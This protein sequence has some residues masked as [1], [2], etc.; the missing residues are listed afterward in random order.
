MAALLV[1]GAAD[2]GWLASSY[3]AWRLGYARQLG[4]PWLVREG[5]PDR[6]LLSTFLVLVAIG[7]GLLLREGWR[8]GAL[9]LV[10]VGMPVLLASL[11]PLYGPVRAIAWIHAY[12]RVPRLAE[13]VGTGERIGLGG[14][15]VCFAS[16][17][18]YGMLS[19]R[20]LQRVGD[21]HG[22]SNWATAREG[23]A[24]GLVGGGEGGIV[25]G[26]RG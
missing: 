6:V 1:L 19:L 4:R 16:T 11:G 14:L 8:R 24:A 13:I 15:L 23:T 25:G 26:R 22:S 17:T 20:R 7:A 18:V 3:M 9:L 10:P 2:G 5:D 12:G 21:L